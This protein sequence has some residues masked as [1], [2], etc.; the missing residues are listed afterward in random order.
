MITE[1]YVSFEVAK[2]LKEKGFKESTQL[3]WYEHLPSPNAVYNSEI[4]KPKRDYFYWE[5]DGERNSPWTNN[6]PVPSYINGEVYSCPTHQMAMKWLRKVHNI[7]ITIIPQ[8][9]KIGVDAI[10]YGIYRITE[11]VYTPLHNGKVDN[12]VDSYEEA[13]ETALKYSLENLI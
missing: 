1:D 2:L 6:S 8:E 12:L 9:I 7:F 5:K 4:G 11:D 3:V 13:V 10:C